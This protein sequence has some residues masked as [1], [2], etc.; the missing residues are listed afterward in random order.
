M[1][2]INV[3]FT[4]AGTND[5]LF[6]ITVLGNIADLE[7]KI[8]NGGLYL[9]GDI[10]SV[11][12]GTGISNVS[13]SLTLDKATA[14]SLGGVQ[15]G[16][17]ITVNNNGVISVAD[18]TTSTKGVV[19][20]ADNTGIANST[21]ANPGGAAQAYAV[22]I[23]VQDAFD[24][25]D[26][27]YVI[28]ANCPTDLTPITGTGSGGGDNPATAWAVKSYIDNGLS[29]KQATLSSSNAGTNISIGAGGVINC[30]YTYTLPTASSSTKGGV[31]IS[32]Y[33]SATPSSITKEDVESSVSVVPSMYFVV[34]GLDELRSGKQDA[35]TKG[36][37]I[38]ITT[39]G[40]TTTISA[41]LTAGFRT[42]ITPGASTTIEQERFFDI[43]TVSGTSVSVYAGHAYKAVA[44]NGAFT[45]NAE[46]CA[47]N[48][49]GLEGHIQIFISGTGYVVTGSNLVLAEELVS[50]SVNNCT[51]RFHSGKAFLSLED[52]L[53]GYITINGGTSGSGSF[54]YGLTTAADEFITFDASTNNTPLYLN[55]ITVSGSKHVVGNNYATIVSGSMNGGTTGT[56][57]YA[58]S[59]SNLTIS[60]G[61][62]TVESG[63]VVENTELNVTG[64]TFTMKEMVV[65]GE[66]NLS[67]EPTLL[68]NSSITGSGVVD[69]ANVSLNVVNGDSTING[70]EIT[71]GA[72]GVNVGNN[73]TASMAGVT[74]NGNTTGGIYIH[75]NGTALL[76]NGELYDNINLGDTESAL[77]LH[78]HVKIHGKIFGNGIVTISEGTIID[79]TGNSETHPISAG[80]GVDGDDA[81]VEVL[82]TGCTVIGSDGSTTW[83]VAAGKY[84][85]LNNDDSIPTSSNAPYVYG[86]KHVCTRTMSGD[87]ITNAV[88]TFTAIELTNFTYD[89]VNQKWDAST[90]NETAVVHN[91]DKMACH[92]A[93]IGLMDNLSTRHI[94]YYVNPNNLT[95]KLDGTDSILTGDDGEVMTEFPESH[96]MRIASTES[97]VDTEYILMSRSKFGYGANTSDWFESF[98]IS[99]DGNTVRK[100]YMGY[101]QASTA[102]INIG[103][104]NKTCLR[105][106][107]GVYPAV[108]T[109]LNN[110]LTY[111]E[112]Y[113]G[114]VCNEKHYEWLHHLFITQKLAA[115]TQGITTGFSEMQDWNANWPR[116]TGRTNVLTESDKAKATSSESTPSAPNIYGGQVVA[117]DATAN[118]PDYDLKAFWRG[119]SI[120][121]NSKNW[122]GVAANS[123]TGTVPSGSE[124]RT[125]FS[126]FAWKNGNDI[127]YTKSDYGATPTVGTPTFTDN[128]C[129]T[130]YGYNTTAYNAPTNKVVA[131]KYFI[132]NPW[133]SIWQNIAGFLPIIGTVGAA[134]KGYWKTLATS[135]YKTLL[136][137][138]HSTTPASGVSWVSHVWPNT[139]NVQTWSDALLP[140][141]VGTATNSF[142]DYFYNSDN[143]SP[144]AGF[145]GGAAYS[146][147]YD[148]LGYVDVG[149]AVGYANTILGARLSA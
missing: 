52:H 36:N 45:I 8:A 110:F 85:Q 26:S 41:A 109:S 80:T 22:K 132:E 2:N 48:K 97:N 115:H 87:T 53:G 106:V 101:Y 146:S 96:F 39:S 139:G 88:H 24:S 141:T 107:S 112:N 68:A 92:F 71:G 119:S 34:Y 148:G 58:V 149:H 21:S 63:K 125:A 144:R 136:T 75:S 30:T 42:K 140:L 84:W 123:V 94:K 131:C 91:A 78:G 23:F 51:V 79:F 145:R 43:E 93:R 66:L 31:N 81:Y 95:K 33:V 11:K 61:I 133:G 82:G 65:D 130:S 27:R 50:D 6:G 37:G 64:G 127:I 35:L 16:S 114:S 89:S 55:A 104:T 14:N 13:G 25:A 59:F 99:P 83:T 117:D 46:A 9:N 28:L 120:T 134:G 44:N 40:T 73:C 103:G 90:L 56:T 105:S 32:T 62:V 54:S 18:A 38:N 49:F 70:V 60:A 142:Q 122:Q 108:S 76:T 12:L 128:T 7:T 57:F 5:N 111:A 124:A 47:A 100:Q 20:L 19:Q 147:S 129:T 86:Y 10:L 113:G 4:D 102:T 29:T 143:A 3:Q 77:V 126:V 74:L 67:V 72:Y 137:Y 121:C 17:N 118:S 135:L 98:K 69:L 1:A 15:I 116:R 138:T